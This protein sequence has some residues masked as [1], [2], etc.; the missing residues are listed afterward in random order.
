MNF[1][2]FFKPKVLYAIAVAT[3]SF[4]VFIP[5]L[6]YVDFLVIPGNDSTLPVAKVCTYISIFGQRL[7]ETTNLIVRIAIPFVLMIIVSVLLILSVF[8][9]R[10]RITRNFLATTQNQV[11]ENKK[12]SKDMK[13]AITSIL[14]NILF[15]IFNLPIAVYV[16][17]PNFFLNK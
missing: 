14:L 3:V 15:L 13:I 9:L 2:I 12:L 10:A 17:I 11:N 6:F 4:M 5:I 8:G 7:V 16:N 1:K